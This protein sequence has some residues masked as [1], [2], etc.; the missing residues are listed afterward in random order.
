MCYIDYLFFNSLT[1]NL[2]KIF[3]WPPGHRDCLSSLAIL[4]CFMSHG[5]SVL[6]NV[7]SHSWK[8]VCVYTKIPHIRNYFLLS[9]TGLLSGC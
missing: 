7:G 8:D 3:V 6:A 2:V 4:L 9:H 5:Y 1:E